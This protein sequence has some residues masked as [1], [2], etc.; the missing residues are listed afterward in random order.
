MNGKLPYEEQLEQAWDEL[1]LPNEDMAWKDMRRRLDEDDDD[2]I[3]VPP[4][5]RGCGAGAL[6]IGLLL[7]GGL[8]LLLRPG[9][10]F[11]KPETVTAQQ[12]EKSNVPKDSSGEEQDVNRNQET[13]IEKSSESGKQQ[14]K[15]IDTLNKI[16]TKATNKNSE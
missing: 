9:K 7:L 5:K 14:N 10:W 13:S 6:L 15:I 2:K 8:W 3:V 16:E 11:L 1:P 4:P 12:K